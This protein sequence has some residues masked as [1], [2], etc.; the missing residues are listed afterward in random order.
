MVCLINYT[1]C[2][3]SPRL[4]I[5]QDV[6]C[7]YIHLGNYNAMIHPPTCI[8]TRTST[9][10][11]TDL[12]RHTHTCSC[13]PQTLPDSWHLCPSQAAVRLPVGWL[14]TTG[15]PQ[16][17]WLSLP[18]LLT[19]LPKSSCSEAIRWMV[20]DNRST[21]AALAGLAKILDNFAQAKLQWGYPLDGCWRQVHHG[22]FSW[23]CKDSWQLYPAE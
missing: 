11:P 10:K 8:C 21:T 19:T 13:E 18:R 20:A 15:P 17:L 7:A 9:S 3:K 14:L 1:T 4:Q 6:V 12:C 22:S 5:W 23:P 2:F 16:Q